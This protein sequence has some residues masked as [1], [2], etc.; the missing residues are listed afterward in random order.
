MR[1]DAMVETKYIDKQ[2]GEEKTSLNRCGVVFFHKD[3]KG[4]TVLWTDSSGENKLVLREPK[5]KDNKGDGDFGSPDL[6][7]EI[8]FK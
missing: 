2:T 7:D 1:W 6:N 8:P 4:A 3:Q 5:P